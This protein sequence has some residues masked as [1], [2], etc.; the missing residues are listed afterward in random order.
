MFGRTKNF[1][2]ITW[3]CKKQGA[4][5]HS[6]TEAEIIA[7]DAGLRLDGLP[8]LTLWEFILSTLDPIDSEPQQLNT[9]A[10]IDS[11]LP[12]DTQELL[13]VDYVPCNIL[14]FQIGLNC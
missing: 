9:R 7:L 10:A 8:S 14:P 6:S 3:M 12:A 1:C 13:N 5:S 2:P 4:V 11:S